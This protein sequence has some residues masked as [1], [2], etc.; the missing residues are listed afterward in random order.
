M[1]KNSEAFQLENH[2]LSRVLDEVNR[3]YDEAMALKERFNEIDLETRKELWD[4]VGSVSIENGLDQITEFMSQIQTLRTNANRQALTQRWLEQHE[5][6]KSRPYFARFDF[7]EQGYSLDQFYIGLF[8]LIDEDSLF[9]IYDWRAP[10]ASLYYDFELGDAAYLCPDGWV[11]GDIQL[12]RQYRIDSGK[13][14]YFFDSSINIED[15]LLQD[16]LTQNTND[17][18][19]IIVTSIQREQNRIIRDESFRH[20]I[21]QGAAGSG[22]T[23]V[24]LH[25]VAYLLYKYRDRVKSDQIVIYS[26]NTQFGDYISAVL[27]E[28]GEDNVKQ[29]TYATLLGDLLKCHKSKEDFKYSMKVLYEGSLDPLRNQSLALKTS[30]RFLMALET[31][32]HKFNEKAVTFQNIKFGEHTVISAS[33]MRTFFDERNYGQPI[34]QRL[35]GL[36]GRI[37]FL[38]EPYLDMRQQALKQALKHKYPDKRALGKAVKLQLNL[39][40]GNFYSHVH[41]I[42]HLNCEQV[43]LSFLKSLKTEQTAEMLSQT[44][45][46]H[47]YF[48]ED[49]IA[50]LYFKLL[51]GDVEPDS[52]I[53]YV[54]IDEAQDYSLI[55]VKLLHALYPN[56]KMTLLGDANQSISAH[57]GYKKLSDFGQVFPEG[58]HAVMTL[59]KTYRS[60]KEITDFANAYL[61]GSPLD[62]AIGRRGEEPKIWLTEN[63]DALVS[64]LKQRITALS[65]KAFHS[66]GILT[67]TEAQAKHLHDR[68]KSSI[69][70]HLITI[71]SLLN[72]NQINILPTYLAKGLEFDAVFVVDFDKQIHAGAK[73]LVLYTAFTRA[74]HHLEVF[75]MKDEQSL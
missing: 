27:P 2:Y 17:K 66:I 39:E 43:Y 26:P 65:D 21:V 18:M 69:H 9:M 48:Y 28:L 10:I 16:A 8:N 7:K 4:S 40:K 49:Q 3:Q 42:L 46:Q 37:E 36:K 73:S 56:A 32:I 30:E 58:S 20:L 29:M 14:N 47:T 44:I 68:L 75:G 72:I 62:N 63:M 54:L 25:R 6:M 24:A 35:K 60:T 50:L 15:Q 23:S 38:L 34:L 70:T 41:R 74:L 11:K 57:Q 51:M 53:K 5:A 67:H 64:Q 13:L 19:K 1:D 61:P 33:E 55:Q 71:D 59:D 31:Y 12:K 22:K 52:Q 45:Q